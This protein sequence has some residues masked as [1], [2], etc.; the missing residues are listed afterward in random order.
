MLAS[1]CKGKLLHK[2]YAYVRENLACGRA[3]QFRKRGDIIPNAT[4][5]RFTLRAWL[6][7]QSEQDG[8]MVPEE[9]DDL[10]WIDLAKDALDAGLEFGELDSVQEAATQAE[11]DSD[12]GQAESDSDSDTN[13]P[14]PLAE[15][16]ESTTQGG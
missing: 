15:I 13:F 6:Q 9:H 2:P 16:G 11:S 10:R 4:A 7:F 8:R 1:S 14:A 12:S 5:T 3:P